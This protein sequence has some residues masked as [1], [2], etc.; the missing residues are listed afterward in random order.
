[1]S[2]VQQTPAIGFSVT[3]NLDGNRQIVLQGFFAAETAAAEANA[4][5]DKTLALADRQRARY[6][7][8]EVEE[9][10]RQHRDTLAQYEEDRSRVDFDH[11]TAQAR[12]QVEISAMEKAREPERAKQLA[13][14]NAEILEVQEVRKETLTGYV[15]AHQRSGRQGSYT[16]RGQEKANLDRIDNGLE[17]LK[18][19]R[20]KTMAEWDA[21][22]DAVLAAAREEMG[23]AEAERGQALQNLAIS[24]TRFEKA[25]AIREEKIASLKARIGD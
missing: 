23:K 13:R 22:Y 6:E 19:A 16:A 3:T 10:L 9:E 14:L 20:D 5:L 11:E 18:E 1:L 2:E 8:P 12:R 7:L 15:Q 4:L 25:I 24:I 21:Q 17:R